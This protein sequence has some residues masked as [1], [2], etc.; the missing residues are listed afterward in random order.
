MSEANSFRSNVSG[1]EF[2]ISSR[3]TCDSSGVVYLL[4]CKVYGKQYVGSTFTSFTIRFNNYK[5]ASRRY[6]KGEVVTQADFLDI[7]LKQI[8]TV[9]WRALVFIS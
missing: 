1:S 9:L 5:S 7:L 3:Y 8:I 6:S 2:E 4:G